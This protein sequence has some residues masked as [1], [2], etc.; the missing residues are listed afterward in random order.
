MREDKKKKVHP[1]LIFLKIPSF[2][3]ESDIGFT[4]S[5]DSFFNSNHIK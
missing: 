4:I 5:M 3:K 2:K 1:Y